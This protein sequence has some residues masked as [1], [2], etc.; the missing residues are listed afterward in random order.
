[1]NINKA[2]KQQCQSYVNRKGKEMPAKVP[3][4]INEHNCRYKCTAN[5]NEEERKA[6][7]LNYHMLSYERQKDLLRLLIPCLEKQRERQVSGERFP[8]N[9]SRS[10]NFLKDGI[11]VR[12]CK[13]FF[14]ATL[15]IS[16]GPIDTVF[17]NLNSSGLFDKSDRRGKKLPK[18]KTS[19]D[20]TN[21]V[22]THIDK[23]PRMESHYCR[24]SS[25]RQYLESNL[26][27]TKMYHLYKNECIESQQPYVSAITYRRIFSTSYNLSFFKPKKDQ[28]LTCVKYA[29]SDNSRKKSLEEEYK[30]HLLRRDNAFQSKAADKERAST[31]NE[32]ISA[33]FDLQSVLQ[34]PSGDVSQLY[35]TRKL[36][37][38]N[39]T[40]YESA[41]PNNAH[42]FCW[43]EIHG[44]RGSCEIATV[45][46][47][48]LQNLPRTT[49][50]VSLFSDTCA[51]QNRNQFVSCMFLYAVRTIDNLEMV[52]HKFMEK[53][54]SY[55]EV[56][57]M[58][59]AIESA[60][61]HVSVYS[62]QDWLNIFHIAR[63]NRLR[64][65]MCKPYNIKQLKYSDFIDFKKLAKDMIKNRYKDETGAKVNWLKIKRLRYEKAKPF[66]IQYSY[67]FYSDYKAINILGRGRPQ[68]EIPSLKS[69]Y[70][71]KIPIS[72]AKKKD[73][74]NLCR[75]EVIPEEYHGW[76]R[77][78]PATDANKDYVPETDCY[79]ESD[80]EFD[81]V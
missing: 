73:L 33:T 22:K 13:Q 18:N 11:M 53:G 58:H 27:I 69:L 71:S 72:T 1:M 20:M 78:L 25:K 49:K 26:S 80:E 56:D 55:M 30:G 8:K 16:H 39:A 4:I 41:P 46:L 51:G 67:D 57:S 19:P 37:A 48:Y 50:R 45:L 38:Y 36:N 62:M 61:K 31:D 64:N 52:E 60:K 28:C 63:S 3:K 17:K 9:Y 10:Y 43:T 42:C 70:N 65:K 15:C 14:C 40:I 21:F 24:K 81:C 54:H 77:E 29:N 23:F 32:F 34:I 47:L 2:K 68:I 59:S 74:M 6:L 66:Q 75:T 76:Y 5:F 44:L 12:V 79:S 7:C 35:Y